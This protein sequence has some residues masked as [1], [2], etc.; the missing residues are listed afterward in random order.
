MAR[1][2]KVAGLVAGVAAV[3]E[4]EAQKEFQA[5]M[6]KFDRQYETPVEENIRFVIFK[7][8]LQRIEERN[9]KGQ[10]RHAVNKFT[11]LSP[12][13]FKRQYTGRTKDPKPDGSD[14]KPYKPHAS[15][16]LTHALANSKDWCKLGACTAVKN[17]GQCGSCWAFGGSEVLESE[18]FT[19]FG[20]LYTLSEQQ[21]S[22]CDSTCGGCAGGNAIYAW[23]YVN[24]NGGQVSEAAYPYPGFTSTTCLEK[25]CTGTCKATSKNQRKANVGDDIG[26]WVSLP[27]GNIGSEADMLT[28][29]QEHTLSVAVN[30]EGVWQSYDGGIVTAKSGCGTDLDHNVQVTGYNAEGNYWIVRNSWGAD[31]G[32]NGFI[33]ISYGS[34][35]CGI[36]DEASFTVATKVSGETTVV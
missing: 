19:T 8:N 36:A 34:D 7:E 6:K 11:D 3:S 14:L 9:A 23:E 20:E 13:E 21:V 12:E 2:L 32:E 1:L 31:W 16:N 22:A 35:V 24:G 17:Q 15:A 4:N 25:A 18:Y 10:E 26:Y 28:A 33:Y 30:A 5:F 27:S 29:F